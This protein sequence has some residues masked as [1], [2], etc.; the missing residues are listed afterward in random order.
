LVNHFGGNKS[1]FLQKNS[2]EYFKTKNIFLIFGRLNYI[3]LFCQFKK[4]QVPLN[5]E[6]THLMGFSLRFLIDIL[7][8]NHKTKDDE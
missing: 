6:K 2:P 4:Y 3:L 1:L 8:N 5:N 7:Y